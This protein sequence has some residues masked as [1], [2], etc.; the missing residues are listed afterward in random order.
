M[1]I[2][3]LL[4]AVRVVIDIASDVVGAYLSK[5]QENKRWERLFKITEIK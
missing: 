5:R 1:I 4:I 2:I 3:F